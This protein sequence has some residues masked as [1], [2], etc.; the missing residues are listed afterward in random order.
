MP[1]A[2][3]LPLFLLLMSAA[4]ADVGM[5]LS[6]QTDARERGQSYSDNQPGAQLGLG[7]DG[8]GGWY[9]GVSLAPVRFD[10]T[11]RGRWWRAY[12]GRVIT[13]R[14]GLDAEAGLVLHR[15]AQL[16][17]YDHAEAF[18]GLLGE[19]WQLR[20]HGAP[21]HYGSGQRSV[22][23]E[24]NLRWPATAP[25]AWLAHAGVL[26]AAGN[27]RWGRPRN[28]DGPTRADLRAG[29]SWQ[30]GEAVE[31]QA[32]WVW[33]SRGGPVVGAGATRRSTAQ[34]TLSAAF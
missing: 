10:A 33:A 30:L 7:W 6:L 19:G 31:L 20:L 16:S 1:A 28:A 22:Y 24:A 11:R 23:L 32:A 15:Y 18:A 2:R 25:L 21:N 9:A 27:S 8:T 14:P 29:G 26:H 34:L 4:R 5:T 17:R 13:L 3:L 12:G